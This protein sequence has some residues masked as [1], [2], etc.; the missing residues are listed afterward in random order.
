MH[1]RSASVRVYEQL[2]FLP[3]S[4]NMS[5]GPTN[6]TSSASGMT[7]IYYKIRRDAMH[8]V[9]KNIAK[10]KKYNVER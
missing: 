6:D 8:R 4:D 1:L 7:S 2:F 3:H 9:S 5:Y 10:R